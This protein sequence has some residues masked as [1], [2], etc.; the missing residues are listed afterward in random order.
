MIVA[1]PV[2]I[3][4]VASHVL[5]ELLRGWADG[6]A[7]RTVAVAGAVALTSYVVLGALAVWAVPVFAVGLFGAVTVAH[8]R[9][10][11]ARSWTV[12]QV[13][14]LVALI[15]ISVVAVPLLT[16]YS[17]GVPGQP[18]PTSPVWS[19]GF[20]GAVVVV[21]GL[22]ATVGLG[23]AFMNAA[24]RP[25]A[26]QMRPGE[27][28]EEGGHVVEPL[29]NG[30]KNAG[31][32]IG[33]YERL[34]IFLFVLADAPTAIGF[35]IAAKSVFRFGDLTDGESRKNAEYLIIGTLMSFAYALVVAYVTRY[36]AGLLLPG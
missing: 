19:I 18:S 27:S 10:M 2:L 13:G 1:A 34:L 28:I 15:P 32:V 26:E 9:P 6:R 24:I 31:R 14:V 17:F 7:G 8:R 3:A 35:L 4:L 36:V 29:E 20:F 16:G 23:G 22:A 11:T 30:F 21:T 25:F 33:Y 5:G 12:V